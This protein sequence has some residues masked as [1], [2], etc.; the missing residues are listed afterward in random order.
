MHYFCDTKLAAR[1]SEELLIVSLLVLANISALHFNS[2]KE[3]QL[4]K[5]N[6]IIIST[7]PIFLWII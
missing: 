6:G 2:L 7:V 5:I 1:F 3:Y 4:I